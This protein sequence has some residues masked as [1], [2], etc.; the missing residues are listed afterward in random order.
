MTARGPLLR[1]LERLRRHFEARAY[2]ARF[3]RLLARL[4]RLE[5][6]IDRLLGG[7]DGPG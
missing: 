5:R 2:G 3:A 6:M 1:E 4:R 7:A